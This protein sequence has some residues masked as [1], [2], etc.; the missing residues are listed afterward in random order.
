MPAKAS[1]VTGAT[2]AQRRSNLDCKGSPR[3]PNAYEDNDSDTSPPKAKKQTVIAPAVNAL[4]N[5][6]SGFENIATSIATLPRM[7]ANLEKT[8]VK[9]EALEN[10]LAKKEGD[11]FAEVKAQMSALEK[12]LSAAKAE[13]ASKISALE[14]RSSTL[15]DKLAAEQ[16]RA[17]K[18]EALASATAQQLVQT[19]SQSKLWHDMFVDLQNRSPAPIRFLSMFLPVLMSS[20]DRSLHRGERKEEKLVSS[21]MMGQ[22]ARKQKELIRAAINSPMPGASSDV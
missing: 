20:P 15:Q 14:S 7:I 17:A 10:N 2:S 22:L 19:E 5:P 4:A 12:L 18:F 6:A 8:S 1:G 21:Q 16:A 3:K 13:A 11:K 9:L